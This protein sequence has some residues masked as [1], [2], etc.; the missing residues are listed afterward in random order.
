ME[1]LYNVFPIINLNV[2]ISILID[3]AASFAYH[4]FPSDVPGR[5]RKAAY[6]ARKGFE[7][8]LSLA[9]NLKYPTTL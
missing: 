7:A 1:R 8:I 5:K 2:S 4:M 3:L 6:A 9:I